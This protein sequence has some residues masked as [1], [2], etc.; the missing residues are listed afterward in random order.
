M[1]QLRFSSQLLVGVLLVLYSGPHFSQVVHP[2]IS[3]HTH[4]VK[5]RGM[6]QVVPPCSGVTGIRAQMDDQFSGP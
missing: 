4:F 1:R 2:G 5:P 3:V 6:N